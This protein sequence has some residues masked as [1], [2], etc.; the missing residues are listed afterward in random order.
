MGQR[1][2]LSIVKTDDCYIIK[3]TSYRDTFTFNNL[4]SNGTMAD[5]SN[6]NSRKEQK[7]KILAYA[8]KNFSK[9][10]IRNVKMDDIAS[11]L[12]IS[13]RTLYELFNDK[14]NLLIECLK[15]SQ[16]RSAVQYA[17]LTKSTDNILELYT[18]WHK[19]K[20]DEIRS[21]N[22]QFFRDLNKYSRVQEYFKEAS[23]LKSKEGLKFINEGIAQGLFREDINYHVLLRISD[24][25]AESIM[26][27]ELYMEYC[28][29]DLF[30][31][32]SIM[33]IRG[34]CTKKGYDL[35]DK[36]IENYKMKNNK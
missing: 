12:G 15:Y 18:K 11:D 1:N 5:R 17:E 29:E 8:I 16:K 6:D 33:S 22:P 30:G 2:D 26:R 31:S 9:N 14:E 24:I 3:E 13:K 21:V 20:I 25:V 4:K 7:D 10:G 28:Y 23:I 19:M 36:Y 35:L 27:N 32:T 34:I